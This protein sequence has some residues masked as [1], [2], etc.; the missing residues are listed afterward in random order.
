MTANNWKVSVITVC[1][2]AEKSI[3]RTIRS[4]L[5]QDYANIEYIIIDGASTDK[6]LEIIKKYEKKIAKIVS[7]KDSGIFDAMNKGLR[8]T[9][10]D[11]ICFLNADDSFYDKEVVNDVVSVFTQYSDADIVYGKLFF[12]N[13]PQGRYFHPDQ[14]NKERKTKLD[15]ILHAMPH[16]AT[17]AR[18]SVFAKAGDF[19]L[20]Y[21]IGA[22]YDWFLRCRNAGVRMRFVDRFISFFSY[23]GVSSRKTHIPE[24]IRLVYAN[25]SL[26]LFSVYAVL[27]SSRFIWGR[28]FEYIIWPLKTKCGKQKR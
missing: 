28:V 18:K 13:V 9:T 17:F 20:Q 15:M 7:E 23:D 8:Y 12:I 24:R 1:F 27:A 4:V 26:P 5:S 16:Q 10:G 2:R 25:S 14:C 19:N 6:T 21:K 11:L 22:D 3:E